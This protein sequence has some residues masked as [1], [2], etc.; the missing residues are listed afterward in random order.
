L[1]LPFIDVGT[2]VLT[3]SSDPTIT[4]AYNFNGINM[5]NGDLSM[6]SPS[7][8]LGVKINISGKNPDGSDL[9][10]DVFHMQAGAE[11]GG[12]TASSA[13]TS[14]AAYIAANTPTLGA[15][16]A[17]ANGCAA[18]PGGCDGLNKPLTCSNCSQYDASLVEIIYG[19]SGTAGLQGHPNAAAVFYMPNADV[20]FGGDSGLNGAMIAHTLTINGGGNTLNI[21]YD[22]SLSGK[23]MTASLPMVSSFSWKKY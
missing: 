9:T 13:A 7:K 21:N 11:A 20:T 19:G 10:T 3:A 5:T 4:N 17:A 12:F 6:Q 2:M 23:G 1:T 8:N 18:N 16:V 22:Q 15:T 14:A